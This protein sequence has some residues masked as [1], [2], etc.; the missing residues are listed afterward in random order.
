MLIIFDQNPSEWTSI[1]LH[2]QMLRVGS[3]TACATVRLHFFLQ[4]DDP[5]ISPFHSQTCHG[6]TNADMST[7]AGFWMGQTSYLPSHTL[8]AW[9][10]S[11]KGMTQHHLGH[12]PAGLIILMT[13]RMT[14]G[15]QNSHSVQNIPCCING[16]AKPK[17]PPHV[18]QTRGPT[19]SSCKLNCRATNLPR[20]VAAG[21]NY[22]NISCGFSRLPKKMHN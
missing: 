15:T 21:K 9:P 8:R 4:K 10:K 6:L 13:L 2:W 3:R 18:K 5:T 19:A 22:G 14:K 7:A 1:F 20:S 11:C 16:R 17:Q 12:V